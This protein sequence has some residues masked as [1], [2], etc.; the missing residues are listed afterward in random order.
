[1][2]VSVKSLCATAVAAA[3]A[4]ACSAG[5]AAAGTGHSSSSRP[6]TVAGRAASWRV[7][8]R[9]AVPAGTAVLQSVTAAG[10]G[11]AW[12]AGL[13]AQ[14]GRASH[15]LLERWSGGRWRPVTVPSSLLRM[16]EAGEP[17]K[18]TSPIVGASSPGNVWVL[19]QLSG[20]WLRWNGRRW[21]EGAIT[22]PKRGTSLGI[23]S[24]LVLGPA[25]VWAF[26]ARVTA[27]ESALP[28]AASFN[29]RSWRSTPMPRDLGLLVSAASAAAP[30]DIWA[31]IGYG[32]QY[33]FP[34]S[35][36]GGALAHWNG[37]AWRQVPLPSALARQGDPTSI[38]AL[39]SRNIWVGGGVAND[40][41][42]G[43]TPLAVQWDGRAWH[44]HRVPVSASRAECVL[45]AI[46][47]PG[48]A[49]Q[50]ALQ[51]CFTGSSLV[52][53][54]QVWVLTGGRWLGPARPRLHGSPLH[55]LGMAPAG[56]SGSVWAVGSIGKEAI[57][58][59]S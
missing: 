38:A 56:P 33:E 16:F 28:F 47:S 46:L 8:A 48:R 40:K 20:K 57:I 41:P 24:L 10:I 15:L 4:V 39:S 29:G 36:N 13:A 18:V 49:G 27:S 6:T 44:L 30:N 14:H 50:L 42:G 7:V 19:N 12:A 43:L 23:T 35:G 53:P 26:G 25:D 58:A 32:A 2:A 17:G 1:M 34:P 22:E 37:D 55:L 5:A 51:D 21:S 31:T 11:G 52:V 3:C 59:R 45:S 9:V 54:S